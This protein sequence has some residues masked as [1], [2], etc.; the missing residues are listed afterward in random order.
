M[1]RLSVVVG[2]T[3]GSNV[4]LRRCLQSLVTQDL[5]PHEILVPYDPA[6]A[7]VTA[8]ETQFPS[9]RFID[10]GGAD[11]A[12]ARA[13]ASREHHDMLRTV[14][15]RSV[16][17]DC[18]ALIEDYHAASPGWTRALVAGLQGHPDAGAVGGAIDCDSDTA[19]GW[20]QWLSDF[21]RY[22]SPMPA[23][24]TSAISDTNVVY[25]LTALARIAD[26]WAEAYREP[27]V[28]RA[29]V[30][31]GQ[32]LFMV[33]DAPVRQRRPPVA[34]S[35]AVRERYVWGRSFGA[36]RPDLSAAGRALLTLLSPVL[37]LL[38]TARIVRTVMARGR[39]MGRLIEAL[40]LV[41]LL[42]ASWTLGEVVG[43]VT[44]KADGGA[45]TT[46]GD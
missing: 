20:A 33:T 12:A 40:P 25:P 23:G 6:C 34:V 14:G 1:T 9:V 16:T 41:L 15:I 3:S 2:L 30:Q 8:L 11:T 10:A 31:S 42:A 32:P 45:G 27:A 46:G 35:A 37:P 38:L 44:G 19:L 39:A 21:G 26:V 18:V 36:T 28:H 17:G 29:L 22:Q 43:Y 24:P 5:A 7:H 4:V 13:G